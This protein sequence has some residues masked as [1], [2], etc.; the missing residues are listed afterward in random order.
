[1][2]VSARYCIKNWGPGSETNPY[3][4][5]FSKAAFAYAALVFGGIALV[6]ALVNFAAPSLFK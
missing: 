4:L 1:M 2:L 5:F 6:F 3:T